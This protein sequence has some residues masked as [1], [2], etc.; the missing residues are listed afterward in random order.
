MPTKT[1]AKKTVAKKTVAK[2]TGTTPPEARP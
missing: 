2:K 1:V